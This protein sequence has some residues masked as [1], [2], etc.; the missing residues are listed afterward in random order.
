[1]EHYA[2]LCTVV[3]KLYSSLCQVPSQK[4]MEI[5]REHCI[6]FCRLFNNIS[7]LYTVAVQEGSVTNDAYT[8]SQSN[9]Q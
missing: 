8:Q 2:I 6:A 1:M 4:I 5:Q 9:L 7:L 3:L